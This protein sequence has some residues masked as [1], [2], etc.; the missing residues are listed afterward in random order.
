MMREKR[1]K[2]NHT[3]AAVAQ[4]I[5]SPGGE[6]EFNPS[7]PSPVNLNINQFGNYPGRSPPKRNGSPGASPSLKGAQAVSISS[8]GEVPQVPEKNLKYF[9]SIF[10]F[11]Q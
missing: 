2:G 7:H 4:S 3:S 1:L 5:T 9:N 8:D 6:T 10:I 11:P